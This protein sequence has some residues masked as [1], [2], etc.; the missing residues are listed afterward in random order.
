[1]VCSSYFATE[2]L[3]FPEDVKCHEAIISSISKPKNK[4]THILKLLIVF[5]EKVEY[6]VSCSYSQQFPKVFKKMPIEVR[7]LYNQLHIVS[8]QF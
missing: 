7:N 4:N 2:F 5:F 8:I 3:L 1:M 6:F